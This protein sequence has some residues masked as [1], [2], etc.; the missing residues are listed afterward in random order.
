M[1]H[2]AD[3]S[4]S[5]ALFSPFSSGCVPW[6]LVHEV[7]SDPELNDDSDENPQASD[8]EPLPLIQL[9]HMCQL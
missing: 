1:G 8:E 7:D 3:E 9:A 6:G 2:P 4:D 5:Y